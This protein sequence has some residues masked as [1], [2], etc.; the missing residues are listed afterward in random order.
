[1]KNNDT[2]TTLRRRVEDSLSNIETLIN[3]ELKYDRLDNVETVRR[4]NYED[5][6]ILSITRY[7]SGFFPS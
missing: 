4:E 2:L 6:R 5:R 1:M 3:E 7:R